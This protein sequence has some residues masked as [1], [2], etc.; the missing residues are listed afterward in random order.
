MLGAHPLSCSCSYWHPQQERAPCGLGPTGKTSPWM[1]G[2][3]QDHLVEVMGPVE[4]MLQWHPLTHAHTLTHNTE[5][6]RWSTLTSC[7]PPTSDRQLHAIRSWVSQVLFSWTENKSCKSTANHTRQWDSHTYNIPPSSSL[8]HSWHH[9][10]P[11][12]L[13]SLMQTLPTVTKCTHFEL[14]PGELCWRAGLGIHD[15]PTQTLLADLTLVNLL[16]NSA[17]YTQCSY[18][19][20]HSQQAPSDNIP[21]QRHNP[22]TY[23]GE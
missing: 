11:M 10:Y 21:T 22:L 15:S 5:A 16:L 3:L 19:V 9:M 23:C 7:S 13:I 12:Q 8:P 17:L 18:T 6:V 4:Y 2:H 1:Q 14:F 20:T